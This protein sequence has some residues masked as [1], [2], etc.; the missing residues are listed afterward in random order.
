MAKPPLLKDL[1]GE[2]RDL[3]IEALQDAAAGN[4]G[5]YDT[6]PPNLLDYVYSPELQKAAQDLLG[7]DLDTAAGRER[8]TAQNKAG[9]ID[10]TFSPQNAGVTAASAA[11]R[12]PK[13]YA[14]T[15]DT[16]YVTFSFYDYKPPFQAKAG[17]TSG[18]GDLGAAYAQYNASVT[19]G[20]DGGLKKADG[21]NNIV[22]YMPEDIQGQYGA[23]WGGA[24]FGVF[25]SDVA[26]AVAGSSGLGG[27][28]ASRLAGSAK[29][30]GYRAAVEALN[31][32]L[33]ASVNANQLMSGVSGTVINPNV[34][35]MYESPELR[36]FNMKFKM[37]ARS[38]GEA[39][40]I[41]KICNTF[42]KAMLPTYGGQA[43]GGIVEN[44]S[45]LLTVPKVCQV[46]FMTASSLNNF[47]PQYKAA[48][49][50][51]VNVNYT[52]DGAWAT[53]EGGTPVATELSVQFKEL[54][55]IFANEVAIDSEKGTF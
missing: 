20:T 53:Y 47:V 3:L 9:K 35:M 13:D 12:Y 33:G 8:A 37:Q 46:N 25:F 22:L 45:A 31:R 16:D 14:I 18:T 28:D 7:N 30:A 6:I 19:L 1:T 2:E 5:A 27:L 50:T 11:L 15:N 21:Y 26:K 55:L 52:P 38:S 17:S 48:A 24:G 51:A 40:D 10:V 29:I 36:T 49:I 44:S 54:K 43:V 39:K 41:K 23:K 32:G 34:E 42:K 4:R